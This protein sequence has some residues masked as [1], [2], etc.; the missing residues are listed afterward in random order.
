MVF[1][2]SSLVLG[3]IRPMLLLDSPRSRVSVAFA[4]RRLTSWASRRLKASVELVQRPEI[5]GAHAR[6]GFPR[7]CRSGI[8]AAA[9]LEARDERLA[10]GK[11]EKRT[12][13]G[14]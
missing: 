1:S 2:P 10:I 4:D 13:W 11:F 9:P 7:H 8:L 5:V 12:A 6:E 3:V 14:R